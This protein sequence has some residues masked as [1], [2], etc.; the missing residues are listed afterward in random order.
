MGFILGPGRP[1]PPI[2]THV[3]TYNTR[4]SYDVWH[5]HGVAGTTSPTINPGPQHVHSMEGTTT[6]DAGHTH[7]YRTT[8]G[9]A[10]RTRPGYH[11]HQYSGIVSVA[12]RQPH[13]HR[14][15]GV[16]SEAPDDL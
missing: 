10:I 11:V 8:T 12:G 6:F 9:P 15:Q 4:T 16:T 1:R 2:K 3:H 7:R 13:T 5:T 14:Y